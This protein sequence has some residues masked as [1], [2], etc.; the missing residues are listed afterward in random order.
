MSCLGCLHS[1]ST[2]LLI[3]VLL[4]YSCWWETSPRFPPTP[5][6]ELGFHSRKAYIFASPPPLPTTSFFF[7]SIDAAIDR[8]LFSQPLFSSAVLTG[9][10]HIYC[11]PTRLTVLVMN[12]LLHLASLSRSSACP[13]PSPLLTFPQI[14]ESVL[15]L[16]ELLK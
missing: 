8:F 15:F 11:K 12:L 5:L 10:L 13:Q 3:D 4:L 6:L 1:T 2:S 9:S 16:I 14:R 7:R